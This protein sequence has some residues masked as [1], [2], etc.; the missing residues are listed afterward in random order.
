MWTPES[1][2]WIQVLA[3]L[4]IKRE[5]VLL[6][7]RRTM[8]VLGEPLSSVEMIYE[9]TFV[10]HSTVSCLAH[11]LLF[12][13]SVILLLLLFNLL[14]LSLAHSLHLVLLLPLVC[15]NKLC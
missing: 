11:L 15:F 7:P 10:K 2:A 14:L 5:P 9:V 1:E 13:R 6:F 8:G 3:V 4:L 12:S